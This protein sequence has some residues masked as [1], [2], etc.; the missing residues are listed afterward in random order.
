MSQR[1]LMFVAF[2]GVVALAACSS[3]TPA[4]TNVAQT[5]HHRIGVP[6]TEATCPPAPNWPINGNLTPDG[7]F[8][9]ASPEQHF[10]GAIGGTLWTIPVGDIDL[11]D[12]S[13]WPFQAPSSPCSV[14]LEGGMPGAIQEV[15]PT[16][17]N[18]QYKVTFSLSGNSD[19]PPMLK[20]VQVSAVPSNAAPQTFHFHANANTGH[21]AQHGV[22]KVK[23]YHFTAGSAST[24]LEF[25]DVTPG[26]SAFGPVVF[27]IIVKP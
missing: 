8:H 5:A 22:Y 27:E 12:G 11:I 20:K 18:H 7:D 17:M 26:G 9:G 21:D 2:A 24:T 25:Q 15:V 6:Q 13:E 10:G 23:H 14:D 19:G 16:Q 1:L 3:S 4:T